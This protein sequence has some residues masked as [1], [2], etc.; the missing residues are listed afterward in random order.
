M[1]RVL[2]NRI[3]WLTVTS[4]VFLFFLVTCHPKK[5]Q[6]IS[7]LSAVPGSSPLFFKVNDPVTFAQSLGKQNYWWHTLVNIEKMRL[8]NSRILAIDSMFNVNA[9]FKDFFA[10]KEVVVSLFPAK[11]HTIESLF[12]IPVDIHGDQKKAESF[13]SGLLKKDQKAAKKRKYNRTNLFEVSSAE[14]EIKF[15]Y[16]FSHNFLIISENTALLEEAINHLGDK[17]AEMPAELASLL[18]TTNNQSQ[19]NIFINHRYAGDI[20]SVPLSGQMKER[21]K[22]L[23]DFS[24]WSELDVTI[25]GEKVILSGFTNGDSQQKYFAPVFQNQQP[26]ISKIE[27]V[28][29]ANTA[30]F[31]GFCISNIEMFFADLNKFQSGKG[32][33]EQRLEQQK[34]IEV[35]TG[36]NIQNLFAEIFDGEMARSG[37][38]LDPTDKKPSMFFTVKTKSGS[39]ALDKL[40]ELI[41]SFSGGQSN[42]DDNLIKE[43]KIDNQTTH[44]IYKFPVTNFASLLFGDMVGNV[45]TEWVAVYNNYLI[46]SDSYAAL[47]K[48]IL[49]N[50]LGET[51]MSDNEYGKFQSGLAS[52]SIYYFYCNT[53]VCF[54]RSSLFF[55]GSISNDI[56]GN[57][58]FRKFRHFSWQIGSS[59]NMLYNNSSIVFDQNLKLKSLPVWQSHLAAPMA[60]KPL[61]IE[62]KYDLQSKEIVL[63]DTQNNLYLLNNVGRIVWQQNIGSPIMGEI[64]LIDLNKSG[65]S[66][67]V[68]NTKEKLYIIDLK[69]NPVRN[70]PIPFRINATNGVSVFDYENTHNYRFF[71]ASEDQVIYAYDQEG[72]LIE[73]WQPYKTDHIITKPIQHFSVEGKDYIV[74]TDRMKDYIFDRKGNIRV[75]TDFVYQHSFN[76]IIYFEKRTS[77]HEPRMVT[78][79]SEGNIHHVYFDGEHKTTTLLPLDDTHF[80]IA[81]NIN[82]DEELEYIFTQTNQVNV[83]NTE[84]ETL[85]NFQFNGLSLEEPA[86]YSFS[87]KEKKIGFKSPSSN[88]IFLINNDGSLCKGFPLDGS[89]VFSIGFISD[90]KSRF[91]LFVGSPDSYLYNFLVE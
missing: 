67:L 6:G 7:A 34:Q 71:I 64:C 29:P 49:S 78:T 44:T 18:K 52:T 27:S 76:N 51:L 82:G 40:K 13:I 16:A 42:V 56:A 83:F 20:L 12:V 23:G 1:K 80:F 57:E 15:G 19:V 36:V 87:P 69:G 81:A 37:I 26:G 54:S 47:G 59:G 24:G 43:F 46:F 63:F 60:M 66:Q 73:G 31:S 38:F 35:K 89:T 14:N 11:D 2:M 30:F 45:G 88:K 10:G 75:Q 61:I 9:G 84:G 65:D 39:F 41:R 62:N 74:A 55:D 72:S 48:V 58:E 33:L 85:F 4:F 28:L 3:Y 17:K 90:D 5:Y 86:T 91:N 8:L 22:Q 32:L 21:N 25:K 68:F 77:K 79:D 50:M 53:S 70:F